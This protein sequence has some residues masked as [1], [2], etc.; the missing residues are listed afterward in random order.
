MC[1]G[2]PWSHSWHLPPVPRVCRVPL[3]LVQRGDLSCNAV[4]TEPFSLHLLLI[5]LI[6]LALVE[7]PNPLCR[8]PFGRL[9]PGQRGCGNLPEVG[10]WSQGPGLCK[11][12]QPGLP[13]CSW[14]LFHMPRD[15]PQH[16]ALQFA[17]NPPSI[18]QLPLRMATPAAAVRTLLDPRHQIP[19]ARGL[20]TREHP[21][22]W[23][24][25]PGA[26]PA[27]LPAKGCP[28]APGNSPCRAPA[29][30]LEQPRAFVV[31][32]LWFPLRTC[33]NEALCIVPLCCFPSLWSLFLCTLLQL[34]A[35][36]GHGPE[37]IS[38]PAAVQRPRGRAA[39]S[40]LPRAP[41]QTRSMSSPE[42]GGVG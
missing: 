4:E 35:G 14:V 3:W 24:L 6:L 23:F 39:S 29:A 2:H 34:C 31:G 21:T 15:L 12:G 11:P 26:S 41:E 40:P 8:A 20:A 38:S 9:A 37:S 27:M 10:S 7:E 32:L 30:R 42:S 1:R 18:F 22:A 17:P 25:C 16:L 28:Q 19:C 13:V 33:K 5:F 36:L